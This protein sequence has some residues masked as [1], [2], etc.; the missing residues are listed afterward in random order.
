MKGKIWPLLRPILYRRLCDKFGP[1]N[2]WEQAG[3]PKGKKEEFEKFISEI[4]SAFTILTEKEVT[5]QA[6]AM[7]IAWAT[8]KQVEIKRKSHTYNYILN[9]AAAYESGFL[10][11]KDFPDC[12]LKEN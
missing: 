4:A 11:H 3:Y 10:Q 6:V 2:K 8:T 12:L 5:A 7:Q 1:Y 9:V